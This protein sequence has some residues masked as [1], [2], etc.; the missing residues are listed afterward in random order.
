MPPRQDAGVSAHG[1][2]AKSPR[3]SLE[4]R[5]LEF[6]KEARTAASLVVPGRDQD[7]LLRRARKAEMLAS[8]TVG[9]SLAD[10]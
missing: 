7:E 1:E 3:M 2:P 5:L 9:L 8:A 10:P 6:A 4:D